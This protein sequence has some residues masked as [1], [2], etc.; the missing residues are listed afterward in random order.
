MINVNAIYEHLDP[1]EK[2]DLFQVAACAT[3]NKIL[4]VVIQMTQQQIIN[5]QSPTDLDHGSLLKFHNDFQLLKQSQQHIYDMVQML[6][7][8]KADVLE[9]AQEGN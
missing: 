8:C 1:Q 4:A 5:L 3:F 7:K 2:T 9:D 6:E